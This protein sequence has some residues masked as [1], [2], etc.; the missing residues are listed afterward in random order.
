MGRYDKFGKYLAEKGVLVYGHDHVGHGNSQGDRVH[1]ES[2]DTYVQ[3]IVSHIEDTK[4]QYSSV[5]SMLL[6]HSMGGLIATLAVEQHPSIVC[7]LLLSGPALDVDPAFGSFS[8]S[9][10]KMVIATIK[11][12]LPQ[13][14][15]LNL[16]SNYIST[17]PEE[18]KIYVEDPLIWQ[19]GMKAR[20][21]YEFGLALTQARAN[22][23][24]IT[25]PLFLMHGSLDRLV[26]I[27]AS[28]FI[29]ANIGSQDV[30]YEVFADNNHEILRD[31][32]QDR[33][34]QLIAN[35]I[36]AHSN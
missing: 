17:I 11:R 13:K 33:A 31:K 28:E 10:L 22:I 12:V 30:Q 26:P 8:F 36:L 4:K 24:N 5:P 23:R 16:D 35:W 7:A 14:E 15:L 27:S 34:I 25:L 20:W 1:V 19:G 9:V 2:F 6:G 29:Q 32:D 18:V 3:D 21:I